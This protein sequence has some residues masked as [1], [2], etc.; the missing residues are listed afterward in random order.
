MDE[1]RPT[2]PQDER[3]EKSDRILKRPHFRQIY[4]SG[5]KFHTPLFTAF[6][7]ATDQAN[8]RIG[9][10][11]TRKVGSSVERN[12]CRRLLREAVRRNKAL[13]F[14]LGVDLVIN[15]KR[16]LVNAPYAGVEAEV[17]RLLSRIRS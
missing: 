3:F 5:R 4:N 7:L 1:T 8:V 13:G 2:E 6:V 17:K 10:T 11:V 15:A 12:R 16:E 9:F 14:G